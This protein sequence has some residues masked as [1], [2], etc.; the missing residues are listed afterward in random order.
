MASKQV[1]ID[2]AAFMYSLTKPHLG[3]P[4]KIMQAIEQY[5]IEEENFEQQ[6]RTMQY[7]ALKNAVALCTWW[8]TGLHQIRVG[9]KMCAALLAS[10]ASSDVA[11]YVQAPWPSFLIELPSDFMYASR[12]LE[13][14]TEDD[15]TA[16]SHVLV[17]ALP[18]DD[19]E[20]GWQ[21]NAYGL[22]TDQVWT[23]SGRLDKFVE[24]AY[25]TDPE[26]PLF[27]ADDATDTDKRSIAM[28]CRLTLNVCLALSDPTNIRSKP[29]SPHMGL[30]PSYKRNG[31]PQSPIYVLGK[32]RMID[33][34]EV[35]SDYLRT[36]KMRKGLTV[37]S[38]VAGHYKTQHHGPKNSLVKIIWLE[39]YPRGP[40]DA[41]TLI[42]PAVL[43]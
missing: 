17:Y 39:P 34:R 4:E 19:V 23:F 5:L 3:N 10:K 9:H 43:V 13:G 26:A 14:H 31:Q 40:T 38:L 12:M 2:Y 35:V 36:G 1:L 25:G 42:S 18:G 29:S 6:P 21:F 28:L 16:L 30:G 11:R 7:Q 24:M 20:R 15:L 22:N 27:G 41:P 32:E 8:E 33:C 37:Q